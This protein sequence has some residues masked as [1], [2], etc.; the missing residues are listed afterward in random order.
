ML[1]IGHALLRDVPR[2]DLPPAAARQHDARRPGRPAADDERHTR[3]DARGT[4]TRTSR[5]GSR[6]KASRSRPSASGRSPARALA[7]RRR[8]ACRRRCCPSRSTPRT[9]SCGPT[10]STALDSDNVDDPALAK[11]GS[12]YVMWYSG[13]PEDGGPPAIFIA[14]STNGTTWTRGNGGAPVLQGT[15]LSFD[16]DGVFGPDVV[17]DPADPATP[18]RMWYSGRAGVFGA[19]GYATSTDGISWTKYPG[20]GQLPLAVLT[21][22]PAGS[23]DSFSA[24]D[25]SV[26]KDG[27]TWKMWYTGDDSSKKRVAYATSTDGITWAKGGK[28]IA[29]E[30]PGVSANIAFGA[31]APDGLEDRQHLLDAAHRPQARRPGRVP[32]EDHGH[33]LDGRSRLGRP[34]PRAQPV[35]L[36]PELRLLEPERPGRAPGSRHS[37]AV[38]ALLLRATRSTRTGTSTRGSASRPR[39]TAARSTRSTVRRPAARRST[40][41]RW[42]PPSTGARHL[43]SRSRP[44]PARRRSS[45]VSTGAREA[46]TS[47]RASAR[48]PRPTAAPGR[49]CPCPRPTAARSS[50]SATRRPSTT[51]G[52]A[53]RAC[54]TTPRRI[55]CSSPASAPAGRARSATRRRP[56][57][58]RRSCPTTPPGRPATRCWRATAPAST[59]AASRIHP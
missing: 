35:R 2:R 1:A 13:T 44:R 23:A 36:E 16:Q 43:A 12:T 24:A 53:I 29:P 55:T 51:A 26:L 59:R 25:P 10:A 28:V 21:H 49:R 6:T 40:S 8:S 46:A 37:G 42:A 58:R 30:D 14:T 17:Y 32:D 54:S 5:T 47:S 33:D 50:G 27:S 34:E 45:P 57:T 18:Y 52:S 20:P 9:R 31:F 3:R 11:V 41:A 19:I 7:L 39:P 4:R 22:G 56:R 15:P 38:Q 48:R